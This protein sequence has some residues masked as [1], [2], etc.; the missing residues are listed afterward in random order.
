[1]ETI[2]LAGGC[3]W[4]TEAVYRALHGVLSVTSGYMG[5]H[6]E[7]PT[8]NQVSSGTTGHAE[9]IKVEYD[10]NIISTEDILA[11]FFD[12]HDPTTLD[13]QGAD[14]GSQY[15]SAIFYTEHIQKDAAEKIIRERAEK[16]P[17]GPSIVTELM[18]AG[19]FYPAEDY[20]HDYFAANPDKMYC[21]L[22]I[23][24]K[25]EKLGKE[26]KNLLKN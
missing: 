15:R 3:F 21:K 23:V 5:G 16:L 4:C 20:H 6:V 10:S 24:P 14:V 26:H 7:N 11:V 12:S 19:E 1:M 9:T 25:I 13:R 18:L 8:Y 2:Y 17:E 22:V